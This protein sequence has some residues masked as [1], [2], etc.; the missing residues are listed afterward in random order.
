MIFGQANTIEWNP[1]NCV[2]SI[3]LNG[4]NTIEL[5]PPIELDFQ[6]FHF[7]NG[8]IKILNTII[9]ITMSGFF[10]LPIDRHK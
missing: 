7:D 4:Q 9:I 3:S 10:H 8:A 2:L 1:L 6:T 5:N